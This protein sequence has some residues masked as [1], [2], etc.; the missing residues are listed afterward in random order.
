LTGRL[1]T[2]PGY[3][4][5]RVRL[6]SALLSV[7]SPARECRVTCEVSAWPGGSKDRQAEADCLIQQAKRERVADAT[8]KFVDR[9]ECRWRNDKG[10]GWRK[11]VRLVRM[12]VL[13]PYWMRQSGLA[14]GVSELDRVR[15]ENDAHVPAVRL[16]END[17][18][19]Q[20]PGRAAAAG[21]DIY[22]WLPLP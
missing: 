20:L 8:G 11:H 7:T 22:H 16:R 15:C 1:G 5:S 21:D 17:E 3:V 19:R 13:H 12:L 9:V 4:L 18:I 6:A 14:R 2:K 10:V